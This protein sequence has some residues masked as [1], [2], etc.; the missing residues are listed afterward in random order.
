MSDFRIRLK[1]GQI[2][3]V[4]VS[5]QLSPRKELT[6]IHVVMT[7]LN[8][9]GYQAAIK[10]DIITRRFGQGKLN[11]VPRAQEEAYTKIIL[12]VPMKNG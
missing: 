8:Q 6:I 7:D 9:G 1:I 11:L 3:T 12:R 10:D 4:L 2:V 5:N